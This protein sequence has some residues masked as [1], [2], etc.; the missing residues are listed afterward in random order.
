IVVGASLSTAVDGYNHALI[1]IDPVTG[2]RT[3]ISD[4]A[5]GSGPSFNFPAPTA[6][7]IMWSV[8][9]EADGSLLVAENGS[10]S[11]VSDSRVIRV[12]PATGNRTLISSAGFNGATQT[13]SP[14]V[15]T[16]LYYD[17]RDFGSNILV[18]GQDQEF[19]LVDP[20]TGARTLYPVG[21]GTGP[22]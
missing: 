3:I 7:G 20:T 13:G 19:A 17:A 9:Y 22:A 16:G 18:A 4:D 14:G 2:D 11:S 1:R 8:H 5:V 10:G 21:G 6:G 15:F 12:D